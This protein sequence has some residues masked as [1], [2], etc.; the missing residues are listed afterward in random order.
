MVR[1]SQTSG[2]CPTYSRRHFKIP[3][4]P[5]KVIVEKVISGDRVV[6]RLILNKTTDTIHYFIIS[7]F[8]NPKN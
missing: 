5:V 4:N 7:W 2:N 3:E 8:E 6:G 1:Q